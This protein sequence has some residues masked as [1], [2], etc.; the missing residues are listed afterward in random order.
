[1]K[2]LRLLLAAGAS[3]AAFS[4]LHATDTSHRAWQWASHYYQ[5]PRPDDLVTNVYSL[6]ASGYFESAGQPAI[7]I[8]FFSTIFAQNPQNV[9]YWLKESANLPEAHRR[10]LVAAAWMAGHP[11]G[12]R[13]LSEMSANEDPQLQAEIKSLLAAGTGPIE[14]TPVL[15]S[16][17]MNLQWG[18]FLATGNE[19]HILNVLTALGSNQP[20]L[21]SSARFA[22]AQNAAAHPRVL[23][24]CREQ[25][26]RQPAGVRAELRAAIN[27]A[28]AK[29]GA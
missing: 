10:V 21:A 16:S 13:M 4:T 9:N 24:I 17:S 23:E 22:L 3:L 26:E 27:E 7:A 28:S 18:A 15:S 20:G 19:Q 14:N 11:T 2:L 8:G 1:M 25:L 5:N 6:S 29:P 12:A